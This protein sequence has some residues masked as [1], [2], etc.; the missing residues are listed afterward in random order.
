VVRVIRQ[1]ARRFRRSTPR[2]VDLLGSIVHAL[3]GGSS[4]LK[5]SIAVLPF[6]NMSGDHEKE[7]FA[8]WHGR[9]DHTV[10]SRVRR[11]L[12]LASDESRWVTGHGKS[13]RLLSA[14]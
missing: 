12:F 1:P 9:G 7:D 4:S 14:I 10:V 8:D 6:T 3:S 11:Y 5:P 13:G 2:S